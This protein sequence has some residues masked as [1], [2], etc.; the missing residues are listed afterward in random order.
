M[1]DYMKQAAR[2]VAGPAPV[3]FTMPVLMIILCIGTIAQKDLGLYEAHV[4]Y[5]QNFI[6][7]F[8]PLPFPG[9]YPLI[10]II[11]LSLFTRFV[12]FS[13][14][15]WRKAGIHLAHLGVLIL[16]L[17]GL[18][19]S[20]Q[21][22]E[23]YLVIPEG[24]SNIFV[25]DYHQR[26]L[27]I[28]KNGNVFA[29]LPHQMIR[30]GKTLTFDDLPFEIDVLQ[31]CRNCEIY[32]REEAPPLQ[33]IETPLQNMAQFMALRPAPLEMDEEVNLYGATILLRDAGED[34]DG[35][36]VIFEAMPNPIEINDGDDVV[37][38]M[39]GK[40]QRMLPFAVQLDNFVR[41][42]YPGSDKA[43][44]YHSDI[45]ILEENGISWPARVEMNKP[46]RY[47]GYTLYQSS[48][49]RADDGNMATVLAVVDNQGWLF[50]YIGT[51][52]MAFGL[53][54]HTL[55]S[56]GARRKT[57][58]KTKLKRERSA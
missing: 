26:E 49:L 33:D 16:L 39:Y 21:A 58:M 29:R 48:F 2:W 53:L 47:Q 6:I 42:N 37:E 19:T 1:V 40:A 4:R 27:L 13:D 5:F 3:F 45:V 7:W 9:A 23:G 54:W 56:V 17:G 14:W 28:V 15:K 22:K 32:K 52:I 12:F 24:Q 18:I 35:L 51:G 11:T 55:L 44:N 43:E 10:G 31:T 38:I 50:P 34:H 46:L 8:G 25:S 30:Q 41:T 20:L 36:Y 57:P